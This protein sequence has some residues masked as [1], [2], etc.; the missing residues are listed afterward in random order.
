MRRMKHIAL[1]FIL[2]LSSTLHSAQDTASFEISAYNIGL[3]S[4]APEGSVYIEIGDAVTG[5]ILDYSTNKIVLPSIEDMLVD[6]IN[7]IDGQYPNHNEKI[8]FSYLIRGEEY[9][10]S[11]TDVTRDNKL[12]YSVSVSMEPFTNTTDDTTIASKFRIQNIT[13]SFEDGS[14]SYKIGECE[15]KHHLVWDN[16]T[17]DIFLGFSN[18]VSSGHVLSGSGIALH[19]WSIEYSK[20]TGE[21]IWDHSY[22]RTSNFQPWYIRGAVSLVFD[23]KAYEDASAGTY[24]STVTLTLKTTD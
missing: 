10:D 1:I 23:R 4:S 12:S 9:L 7:N 6:D 13:A 15:N 17:T 11:V 19:N 14:S 22:T 2:L 8:V 3:D 18:S 20:C 5:G 24:T 16:E 21:G